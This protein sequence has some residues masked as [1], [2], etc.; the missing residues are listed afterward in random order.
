M[1]DPSPRLL[2]VFGELQAA[3]EPPSGA[4][5]Y[6]VGLFVPLKVKV[7]LLAVVLAGGPLWMV[8][9]GGGVAVG[10]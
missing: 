5:R 1:C 7:A 6:E 4:Q 10:S 9:T 3:N 2:Y 8:M